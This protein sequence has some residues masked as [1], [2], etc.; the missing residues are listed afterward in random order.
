[1]KWIGQHIWSFISRFRNDVYLEDIDTGTIASGGNLGLDSD[2]KI[3]KATVSSGSGDITSIQIATDD[4][5]NPALQASG[6]AEF[7]FLSQAGSGLTV[8]NS[9]TSNITIGMGKAGSATTGTASFSS[10][11]FAVSGAGHVTAN[12][13]STTARGSASFDTNN[14]TVSSGAVSAKTA[15]TTVEGMT[16]LI[17]ENDMASNSSTKPPTQSSVKAYVDANT[18]T[19]PTSA[20]NKHIPTGGS[21]GQFLKYDS[22]GTAVWAADNNTTY[23][24]GDGGLTTND[25]T[26]ADHSKLNAIEA[27]ADVT[28]AVNVAAAGAFMASGVID[29]NDMAT[30]STTKVPT[31][32]SVK[33]FVEAKYSTS[34]IT[35]SVKTNA[36]FDT[37]Y[38]MMHGNGI[39]GGLVGIDSGVD[40]ATDFGGVTAE[41][42]N[43]A[44][45]ETCS[46]ATGSLE[47]Q[48]PIPE[49]CKLMGFYATTSTTSTNTA[50][51]DTGVAIW[52]MPE[53]GVNWGGSTPG[54]ATLIHKSDSSRAG[55]TGD[56]GNKIKVQKV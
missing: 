44:T 43:G 24:V 8:T 12:A 4:G 10:A 28:D 48:I 36:T 31:Q 15:S 42:G 25:F 56:C 5:I 26:N 39:S 38:I 14:F 1:M 30:A 54:T 32:S 41:K 45:T 22:S 9:N 20:G 46:V 23:S 55:M 27:S 33:S 37:N 19:H 11:D 21:S 35:F 29:E 49:T 53:S 13:A 47:Q 2:N 7:R 16:T 3:V 17:S 40:S 50:A 51:H 18:Y 6:A 34:Y 52:H